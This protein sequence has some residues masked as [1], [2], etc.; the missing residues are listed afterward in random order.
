ME[1]IDLIRRIGRRRLV[2]LDSPATTSAERY[3]RDG[4]LKRT[5]RNQGCLMAWRLGVPADTIAR[6]YAGGARTASIKSP[7]PASS[8]S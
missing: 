7:G 8:L 3:M 4:Y 5:L 6:A 1:D 2:M